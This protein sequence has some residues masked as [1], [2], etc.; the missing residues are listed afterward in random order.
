MSRR[1]LLQL[2]TR[3]IQTQLLAWL[4]LIILPI[5][6][7]G[8]TAVW[9]VNWR[10]T[11]VVRSTLENDHRLESAR[12]KQALAQYALGARAIA[13]DEKLVA[14]LSKIGKEDSFLLQSRNSVPHLPLQWHAENIFSNALMLGSEITDLK[15][16]LPDKTT[17][18]KTTGFSWQP[19]DRSIFDEAAA[20]RQVKFGNA[21]I[22]MKGQTLLG[23]VA[24]VFDPME[25][26]Q[27]FVALE[28]RLGPIV[29]L[30]VQHE[31]FGSTYESH[32]AQPNA[33]GDAEFIT[34]LR[35]KRDAAFNVVVPKSK[36]KPI[37][38][39]LESPDRQIV[40]EK[41][42]RNEDSILA[43]STIAATGWGLVVKIDK[44]EAYGPVADLQRLI[45]FGA[46]AAM[47]CTLLGWQLLARPLIVRLQNTA[48]AADRIAGGD[49]ESQIMDN[50]SD[51]IG[52][53]S[54]SIDSLA[55]DLKRD[56]TLRQQ[57]EKRLQHQAS[58]DDLTGS[59]NRKYLRSLVDAIN[60]NGTV[61][62]ASILFLDLDGF[63]SINDT[64]GHHIGDEL[65]VDVAS[66]LL[67]AL[68]KRAKLARWGVGLRKVGVSIGVS[69]TSNNLDLARCIQAADAQMYQIKQQRKRVIDTQAKAAND[70]IQPKSRPQDDFKNSA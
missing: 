35:F 53:M 29:D 59:Y 31:E 11:Q 43:I 6:A 40:Y 38:W 10:M 42:Y 2:M 12:I 5:C 67:K 51:E 7:A 54:R 48:K 3:S 61:F 1:S 9:V 33:N 44:E 64:C 60:K 27:G 36:D 52:A 63:K 55:Q 20:Q 8:V 16:L 69:T 56:K 49:F 21:F 66:A 23:M 26:L 15:F 18:G 17:V 47:F 32:I 19:Y 57:A 14:A 68:P 65:L 28:M 30:V 22:N 62:Q 70:L 13:V 4:L 41:D 58:H 45:I 46:L 24:P 50:S 39:S 25:Q 37:N 34:L